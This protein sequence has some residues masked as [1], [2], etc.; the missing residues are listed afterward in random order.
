MQIHR[1]V[2]QIQ[3]AGLL[4]MVVTVSYAVIEYLVQFSEFFLTLSIPAQNVSSNK[5]ASDV[6]S[7]V[8]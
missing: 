7:E 4:K 3:N 6:N 8:A 2:A 5:F 1:K